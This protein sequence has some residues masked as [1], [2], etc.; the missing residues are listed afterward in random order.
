VV[1]RGH[2]RQLEGAADEAAQLLDEGITIYSQQGKRS[3]LRWAQGLRAACDIHAGQHAAARDR[4]LPLL[5]RGDVEEHFVSTQVLPALA[6]AYLELGETDQ[7]SATAQDALRRL[8][9]GGNQFS[10]VEGLHVQALIAR[11]QRRWVVAERALEEGL[12]L[13]RTMPRP[14]AEGRLLRDHGVLLAEQGQR[15]RACDRQR[16][17]L[18]IFRRLG[19]WW[20]VECTERD[21]QVCR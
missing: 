17:A 7:A 11:R 3:G 18:T 14:H 12:A 13:A 16:A 9:S 15:A 5:D 8:R 19:A 2:L 4:L 21:L 1:A 10:L 6:W 20:D